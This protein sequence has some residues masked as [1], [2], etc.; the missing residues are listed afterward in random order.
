MKY[1][2]DKTIY[3]VQT[4]VWYSFFDVLGGREG[5]NGRITKKN[6]II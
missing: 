1:T 4:W 5:G 3:R 6:V 2:K